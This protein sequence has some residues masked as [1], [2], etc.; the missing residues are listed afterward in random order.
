MV[1]IRSEVYVSENG[2]YTS[3]KL[4]NFSISSPCADPAQNWLTQFYDAVQV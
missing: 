1:L 3:Q 4:D 2:Y